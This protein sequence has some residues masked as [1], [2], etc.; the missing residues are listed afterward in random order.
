MKFP[1]YTNFMASITTAKNNKLSKWL[2]KRKRKKAKVRK[3]VLKLRVTQSRQRNSLTLKTHSMVL[4]NVLSNSPSTRNPN[5]SLRI[6]YLMH[7]L[8]SRLNLSQDR[9][10]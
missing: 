3:R 10:I 6:N 7:T 2:L 8:K 5:K 4:S 9:L 1:D